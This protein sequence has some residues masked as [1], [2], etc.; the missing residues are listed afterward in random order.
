MLAAGRAS[1]FGGAKLLAPLHGRPVLAHVLDTVTLAR[2]AST[3]AGAD[4]HFRVTVPLRAGINVI[5]ATATHGTDATG[6][7]QATV[8]S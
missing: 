6:W 1:R 2:A 8:K 5:T 4:G 7:T 3:V